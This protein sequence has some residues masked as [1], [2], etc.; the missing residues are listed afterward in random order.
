MSEPERLHLLFY[1]YVPDI[2][3]RRGP[4]REGHLALLRR[5]K[6]E[7]RVVMAGA[8]GDPPSGGL[9]VLRIADPAEAEALIGE[10]P[11]VAAGL[12]AS[13]RVEPWNVVV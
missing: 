11:Y 8:T 2:V 1:D 3:E 4:H 10:D 12:V 13:W 9:L 5:W 6:D 7:G